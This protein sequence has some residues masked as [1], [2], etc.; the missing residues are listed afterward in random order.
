MRSATI[1]CLVLMAGLAHGQRSVVVPG[2]RAT[3]P[4]NGSGG[5][6]FS[7]HP[8]PRIWQHLFSVQPTMVGAVRGLA[9]R[10]YFLPT[11]SPA[12]SV[13]LALLM[14]HVPHDMLH[15]SPLLPAN[16]GADAVVTMGLRSV[17]FPAV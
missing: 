15:P 17:A 7:H 10:R 2:H 9:F 1:V 6:D 16:R 12:F 13:E 5:V 4:G 8:L 11:A 3:V 14:S